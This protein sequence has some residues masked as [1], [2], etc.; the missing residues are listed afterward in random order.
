MPCGRDSLG[1]CSGACHAPAALV[2]RH[3]RDNVP[4]RPV[5][6]TAIAVG[7]ECRFNPILADRPR[8]PHQEPEDASSP[9]NTA[10]SSP[11]RKQRGAQR[12]QREPVAH[13][14]HIQKN[15]NAR[16]EQTLAAITRRSGQRHIQRH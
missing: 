14:W 3:R 10:P 8:S 4:L 5:A 16:Q 2:R 9:Y 15:T 11:G 6:T 12:T 1:R 7:S 13:H